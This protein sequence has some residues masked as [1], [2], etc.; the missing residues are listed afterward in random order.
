MEVK[1]ELEIRKLSP[2]YRDT[3]V[4]ILEEND[5]WKLLMASIPEILQK[6]NYECRVGHHNLARYN[7]EHVG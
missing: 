2:K 1:R 4:R 5:D 7:S 6:N 3:L